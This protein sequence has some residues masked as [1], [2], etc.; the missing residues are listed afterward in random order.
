MI[1]KPWADSFYHAAI[2]RMFRDAH[3]MGTLENILLPGQ[4]APIYHYAS[5]S[6]PALLCAAADTPC[7]LSLTAF[8]VPLGIVLTG[9]AAFAL[10][11]SWWGPGAGLG[12]V[13]ALLLLPDASFYG[14]KNPF[15]SADWLQQIAPSGA[16]GVKRSRWRGGLVVEGCRDFNARV[17]ACGFLAAGTV[18]FYKRAH[19]FVANAFLIWVAP[20]ARASPAFALRGGWVGPSPPWR[21]ISG[22]RA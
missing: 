15:L 7:Y 13:I 19:L 5:Y 6:I 11:K 18:V 8:Q 10:G 21:S 16:Y 20:L 22:S 9:F 17:I 12:A 4:S 3:G 14:V 1:V 2:V